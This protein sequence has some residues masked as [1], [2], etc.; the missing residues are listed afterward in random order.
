MHYTFL[1]LSHIYAYM[2]VRDEPELEEH[3]E[4][5]QAKDTSPNPE[6]GKPQCI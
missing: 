4:Q 6:Q 1:I 2:L 3:L 5:V